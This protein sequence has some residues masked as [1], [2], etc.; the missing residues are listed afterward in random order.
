[1]VGKPR[2]AG[3]GA[4]RRGS[5]DKRSGMSTM[6]LRPMRAVSVTVR[7]RENESIASGNGSNVERAI[8]GRGSQDTSSERLMGT[9][10][11][12]LMLSEKSRR[13]WEGWMGVG[14]W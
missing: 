12:V 14:G 11:V 5:G 8:G 3:I 10:R 13:A 7:G 9:E 4:E 2:R 6:L 1:M